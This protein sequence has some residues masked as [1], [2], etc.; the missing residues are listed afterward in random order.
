[1]I[2][3]GFIKEILGT[4]EWT[5]KEGEKRQS[6]KMVL[7]IPYVSKDGQEHDD[8]LMGEMNYGNPAFFEGV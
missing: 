3:K 7:S 5:N 1:M 8:E 4:R 6:V 2:I